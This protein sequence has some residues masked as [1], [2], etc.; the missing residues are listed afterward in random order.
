KAVSGKLSESIEVVG[1]RQRQVGVSGMEVQSPGKAA[2]ILNALA[3]G[4]PTRRIE[5]QFRVGGSL[6]TRM[7]RDHHEVLREARLVRAQAAAEVADKARE[8]LAQKIDQLSGDEQALAKANLK[9]MGI[10]FGIVT[11]KAQLLA[12]D[13]TLIVQDQTP[14][15]TLQDAIDLIEDA[16]EKVRQSETERIG[17]D[18]DSTALEPDQSSL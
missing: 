16:K 10:T 12:N 18:S 8:L 17:L 9:D 15:V 4:E 3:D 5:R 7:R 1:E 2:R 14:K 6:L 13:P 11:D